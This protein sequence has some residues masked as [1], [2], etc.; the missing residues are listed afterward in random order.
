MMLNSS[1]LSPNKDTKNRQTSLSELHKLEHLAKIPRDDD[2]LSE[3]KLRNSLK[4][5]P[6]SLPLSPCCPDKAIRERRLFV[7]WRRIF[8]VP[9][10]STL[11]SRNSRQIVN[12]ISGGSNSYADSGAGR[13]ESRRRCR[14]R[15]ARQESRAQR[16]SPPGATGIRR[17]RTGIRNFSRACFRRRCSPSP[18]R[19]Q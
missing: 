14:N 5:F 3:E 9:R 15:E 1:V 13:S 11:R 18:V 16:E 7:V 4:Y 19:M 6:I 2:L 12:Y 8:D 10:R 17:N